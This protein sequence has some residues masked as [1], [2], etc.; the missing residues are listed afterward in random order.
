M[1]YI[2]QRIASEELEYVDASLRV[3]LSVHAGL[4][5]FSLLTWGTEEKKRQR[6]T[7]GLSAFIL[8]RAFSGPSVRLPCRSADAA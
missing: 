5:G 7:S 8:E 6:D 3:I 1:D 2:S 4:S